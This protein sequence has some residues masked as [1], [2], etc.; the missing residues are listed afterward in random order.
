MGADALQLRGWLPDD[1]LGLYQGTVDDG[2]WRHALQRIAHRLGALNCS[3]AGFDITAR[4]W[5]TSHSCHAFDGAWFDDYREYYADRSPMRPVL[6]RDENIGR[7]LVSHAMMEPSD[8]Q[9][10]EFYNDY[11]RRFGVGSMMA[12]VFERSSTHIAYLAL[13]RSEDQPPFDTAAAEHLQA[14]VPH[15]RNAYYLRN[16]MAALAQHED[17]A[18]GFLDSRR[19]G[20]IY[21]DTEG[22]MLSANSEATRMLQAANGLR[23]IAG[24]IEPVCPA[25][26]DRFEAMVRRA[27]SFHRDPAAGAEF[28]PCG[29]I[30]LSDAEGQA[31]CTVCVI[32][33]IGRKIFMVHDR[34]AAAIRIIPAEDSPADGI[35]R[36]SQFNLTPAEMRLASLLAE[37]VPQKQAAWQLGISPNTLSTQRKSLYRKLGVNRQ[38][39]LVRRL[40]LSRA[41]R[42]SR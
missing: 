22:R 28:D 11:W 35:Q 14:L 1:I 37:G 32:P 25:D 19:Q 29:T 6:M 2:L 39:D 20:L 10:S 4:E 42:P 41:R 27:C 24:R 21:L 15:I 16:R 18:F 5:L 40:Q 3:I 31:I 8:L 13:H 7:V 33:V 36:W 26:R 17:I 38:Y 12:T 34:I 23:C 9:R 30:Q